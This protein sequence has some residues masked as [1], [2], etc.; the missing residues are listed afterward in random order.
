MKLV[1]AMVIFVI[2]ANVLSL[3]VQA[4]VPQFGTSEIYRV[5][6]EA[7]PSAITAFGSINDSINPQ[8]QGAVQNQKDSFQQVTDWLGIGFVLKL[9]QV[10]GGLLY[11]FPQMLK[12]IFSPYLSAGVSF[13]IFT[14]FSN[15]ILTAMYAFWI[16]TLWTGK[17]A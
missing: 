2:A 5:G 14:V 15:F 17:D 9:A 16:F 3:L 1:T 11:G 7:D 4:V 8:G 10:I 6:L 13:M 12:G